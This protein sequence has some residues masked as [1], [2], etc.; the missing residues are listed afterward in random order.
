M[1]EYEKLSRLFYKLSTSEFTKEWEKRTSGYGSFQSPFILRAFRKGR[2]DSEA[3]NA[4]YVNIAKLTVLNNQVLKNSSK[5]IGFIN[6]LPEFVIEPYFHK[7][8]INEAQS[9]NEIEGVRSSKKELSEVLRKLHEPKTKKFKGLMKT[10]LHIERIPPFLSLADFRKLYDELVADEIDPRNAPDG[11]LFRAGYVEVNDGANVTHIGVRSE[12]QI[13]QALEELI[14]FLESDDHPELFRYM[15]AHYYYEYIHP[16]YDG[17]GRTGRLFVCSYL[18][19]YLERYS[20]ITFSNAINKNKQKYYKALEEVP[21]PLN[22]GELTFFLIDMLELLYEGQRELIDDLELNMIKK[23]KID[24]FFSEP[25]WL[26]KDEESRLLKFMT[27][28]T[29]FNDNDAVIPLESILRITGYTRYM[30]NKNM[31]PLIEE[32]YV[33]IVNHRPKAYKL[34]DAFLNRMLP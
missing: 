15:A 11:R 9:N 7:L 21:N 10:Y 32:G 24:E 23:N 31:G 27:L 2:L 17:N 29:V 33:E 28:V 30:A 25:Q 13:E 4:F 14:R 22:K 5:I 16:F 1:A 6:R 8:I 12:E 3:Y 34:T 19:R 20:A 18:S 26:A